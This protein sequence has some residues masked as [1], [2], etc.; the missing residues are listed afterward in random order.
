MEAVRIDSELGVCKPGD[1]QWDL[2]QRLALCAAHDPRLAG[3]SFRLGPPGPACAAPPAMAAYVW[4]PA[5]Q[6]D[7][8]H[9]ADGSGWGFR[10]HLQLHPRRDVQALEEGY[11][12]YDITVLEPAADAERRGIRNAGFKIPASANREALFDVIH[13]HALRYLSAD[14]DGRV[15]GGTRKLLG[16]EITNAGAGPTHRGAHLPRQRRARIARHGPLELPDVDAGV[17]G[18]KNGQREPLD[19]YQRLVNS[20]FILNVNRARLLQ[21]FQLSGLGCQRG[22]GVSQVPGEAAGL[23]VA[24]GARAFRTLEGLS[25]GPGGQYERMM[26]G[27]V[28]LATRS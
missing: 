27:T 22:G 19:V 16:A 18:Y 12:A 24:T 17:R 15:P 2:A 6:P 5:R 7:R 21:E 4:D 14:L 25:E 9:G 23:A 13:A 1:P 8:D 20:N 10:V 11:D 26:A 3:P 28:R